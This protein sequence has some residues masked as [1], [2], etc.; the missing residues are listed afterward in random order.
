MTISNSKTLSEILADYI[1]PAHMYNGIDKRAE[2]L[3]AI[4]TLVEGAKPELKHVSNYDTTK[5]SQ[6]DTDLI[7]I[8]F[9][10]GVK[11]YEQNL[12]ELLK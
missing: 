2:A 9:N 5:S 7:N 6:P 8:G 3:H 11:I 1:M 12:K 4:A 10:E